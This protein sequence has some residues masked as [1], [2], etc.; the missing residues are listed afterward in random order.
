MKTLDKTGQELYDE[1]SE[2][3]QIIKTVTGI[4]ELYTEGDIIDN[5]H[6]MSYPKEKA[7]L[8]LMSVTIFSIT[9][10]DEHI[11]NRVYSWIEL[12]LDVTRWFERELNW[13]QRQ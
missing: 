6:Q 9:E 3:K 13:E 12:G 4:E 11:V 2:V 1:L 5:M 10:G 7:E 8:A